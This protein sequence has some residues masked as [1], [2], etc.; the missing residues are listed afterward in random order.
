M[1]HDQELREKILRYIQGE[2]NASEEHAFEKAMLEDP[3][4]EDAV[5]GIQKEKSLPKI[6]AELNALDRRIQTS[7]TSKSSKIFF[8]QMAAVFLIIVG[9]GIVILLR[10]QETKTSSPLAFENN[11]EKQSDSA[12][13]LNPNIQQRPLADA[14]VSNK[15]LS[16]A[17]GV[18]TIESSP[19]I[20]MDHESPMQEKELEE[21]STL[22]AA[23]AAVGAAQN[24]ED[25]SLNSAGAAPILTESRDPKETI[26]EELLAWANSLQ[27]NQS[28][29]S[30]QLSNQSIEKKSNN[31]KSISQSPTASEA[32]PPSANAAPNEINTITQLIR[33]GNNSLAE[34]KITQ[35]EKKFANDKS[36]Y[37]LK[38][39]LEFKRGN[40][41]KA[42]QHLKS[43][44]NTPYEQEAIQFE[45]KINR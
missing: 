31:K 22:Y 30:Q 40:K 10:I 6:Q 44:K 27:S 38:S 3:F 45:T 23:D 25:F 34:Q 13:T 15:D 41:A 8:Y 1:N 35:Y 26:T 7:S 39:A 28:A 17:P 11:Q 20:A 2:M 4:L 32:L 18:K 5:E 21:S 42:I 14:P 33:N 24:T 29:R 19:R 12:A 36:I 43:L 9:T 37:I 16:P